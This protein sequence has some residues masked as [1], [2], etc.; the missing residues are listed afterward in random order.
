MKVHITLRTRLVILVLAAIVPL[1]FLS[2][3][4][5]VY[6][7]NDAVERATTDLEFAA[8]LAASSQQRLADTARQVLTA[9]LPA[10]DLR[11][12]GRARCDRFLAE[13]IRQFPLYP[14]L[15]VINAEGQSICSGV[16]GTRLGYLGDR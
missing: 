4:K 14:N 8:S 7:A 13:L 15:G 9:I 10:P 3:I 1:F 6:S 12:D 5:A 2:L 11:K 16:D